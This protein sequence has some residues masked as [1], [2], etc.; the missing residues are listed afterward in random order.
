MAES[1]LPHL[2]AVLQPPNIKPISNGVNGSHENNITSPSN[3]I[4]PT[5]SLPS[6]DLFED[7]FVTFN[8]NTTSIEYEP[9]DDDDGFVD[10]LELARIRHLSTIVEGVVE[11]C[12]SDDDDYIKLDTISEA[13]DV[14]SV[15]ILS[16]IASKSPTESQNVIDMTDSQLSPILDHDYD[17]VPVGPSIA[18]PNSLS[19]DNVKDESP[20]QEDINK[21]NTTSET[22]ADSDTTTTKSE[23][24]VHNVVDM[25]NEG[26]TPSPDGF[27]AMLS[28]AL[29]SPPDLN[30]HDSGMV[31]GSLASPLTGDWLLQ[32]DQVN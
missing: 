10:Q 21:S 14:N 11:N 24:T 30:E 19:H 25:T 32:S 1:S 27:L 5:S 22:S 6:I 29:A 7:S 9:E 2:E 17:E 28:S 3:E 23:E 31:K 18:L 8:T 15:D 20:S 16:S 12:S 26:T 4:E 13:M